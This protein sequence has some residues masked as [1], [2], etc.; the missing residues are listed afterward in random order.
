MYE[1]NVSNRFQLKEFRVLNSKYFVFRVYNYN[2]FL[3]GFKFKA[4]GYHKKVLKFKSSLFSL[5]SV[6]WLKNE[7]HK[8]PVPVLSQIL[9]LQHGKMP[10][11]H[12]C[13]LNLTYKFIPPHWVFQ[14]G[15]VSITK[16]ENT[17]NLS[18]YNTGGYGHLI[19]EILPTY[20]WIKSH[21]FTLKI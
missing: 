5:K 12:R 2:Y 18:L 4:I 20:I 17:F 1:F 16:E 15:I 6:S 10:I 13:D 21:G 7:W 14:E 19:S 3:I 9:S 11:E 8:L